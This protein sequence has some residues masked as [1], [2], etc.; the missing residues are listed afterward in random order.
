MSTGFTKSIVFWWFSISFWVI[1]SIDWGPQITLP[2]F[3][4]GVK[5]LH[6]TDLALGYMLYECLC[7]SYLSLRQEIF[8]SCYL[9]WVPGLG[10]ENTMMDKTDLPPNP[11]YLFLMAYIFK[12]FILMPIWLMN[13]I[14]LK[15]E[16]GYIE[17]ACISVLLKS[18]RSHFS[19]LYYLLNK[20]KTPSWYRLTLLTDTILSDIVHSCPWPVFPR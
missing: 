13:S 8:T 14:N 18:E 17:Q 11:N 5:C 2:K 10:A 19:E 1:F 6:H 12:C 9:F 7:N 20:L 4:L 3:S 16:L 15:K